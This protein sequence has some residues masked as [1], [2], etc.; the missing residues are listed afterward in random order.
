VALREIPGKLTLSGNG[1]LIIRLAENDT[2]GWAAF[3]GEY[4]C[5]A[6]NLYTQAQRVAFIH[7]RNYVPPGQFSHLS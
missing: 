4:K 2:Q 6:T 7:V 1:S 5:R 3:H